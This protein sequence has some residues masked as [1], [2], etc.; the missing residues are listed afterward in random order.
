[1]VCREILTSRRLCFAPPGSRCISGVRSQVHWRRDCG[2]YSHAYG[3]NRCG[4]RDVAKRAH[5]TTGQIFR[6][7]IAHG[8]TTRNPAVDFNPSD[9]LAEARSE[10]FARVDVRD[11]PTLLSKIHPGKQ[12]TRGAA[13]V[14]LVRRSMC[15][16]RVQLNHLVTR[17]LAIGQRP[18]STHPLQRPFSWLPDHP[19]KG[20]RIVNYA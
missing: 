2:R 13:L 1:M 19:V 11:L 17:P 7:A 3:C 4:A 20:I 6:F 18:T 5:E 14:S 10:N 15:A 12:L 16:S 9:I 8:I